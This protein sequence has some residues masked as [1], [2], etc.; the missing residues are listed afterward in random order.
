[1]QVE[2]T[3]EIIGDMPFT[4]RFATV[5][6]SLDSVAFFHCTP[7]PSCFPVD[8][9]NLPCAHCYTRVSIYKYP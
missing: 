1:M 3:Y 4:T 2:I 6:Q 5:S 8:S 7:I 9:M